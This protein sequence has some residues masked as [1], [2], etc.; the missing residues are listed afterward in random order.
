MNKVHVRHSTI[1]AVSSADSGERFLKD[2]EF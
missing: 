2:L 1:S